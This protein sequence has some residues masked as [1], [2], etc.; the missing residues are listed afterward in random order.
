MAEVSAKIMLFATLRKKY[1]VKDLNV[2]C[3]GTLF[4]LIEN[5]SKFLENPSLTM[6]M[7]KIKERLGKMLSS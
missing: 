7:T 6:F 3:D 1:G 5:A 4:D 2:K